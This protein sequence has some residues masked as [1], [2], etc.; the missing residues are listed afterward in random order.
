[1][2]AD[3]INLQLT[4]AK[5]D[6]ESSTQA[7]TVLQKQ[8]DHLASQQGHWD[9]LRHTAEHIETITSML[10]HAD[11]EQVKELRRVRDRN[12]VLELEHIALQKRLKDHESKITNSERAL[13][14]AR[15]SLATANQRCS[16]WERR[17]KESEGKFELMQTQLDQLEQTHSQLETDHALAK[18]QL[19]ETEAEE[20]SVKVGPS[21]QYVLLSADST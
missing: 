20:R 12:Q 9:E 4:F 2:Q 14:T 16:D 6:Q 17:A 13:L 21:C 10:S 1:M 7:L 11:D 8:Y 3:K 5:R 19:E 15:Q 18:M